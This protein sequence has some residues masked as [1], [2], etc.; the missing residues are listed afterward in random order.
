MTG[1]KLDYRVQTMDSDDARDEYVMYMYSFMEQYISASHASQRSPLKLY[2]AR[3]LSPANNK[4]TPCQMTD[5]PPL[6]E[7]R[8]NRNARLLQTFETYSVFE[9]E[10]AAF[11]KSSFS[12][13]PF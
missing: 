8:Q 5:R 6:S 1:P 13:Q 9:R 11:L 3:L 7:L 10:N 4:T 12:E 2:I